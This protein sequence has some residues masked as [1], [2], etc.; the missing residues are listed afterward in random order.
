MSGPPIVD[1]PSVRTTAGF[2]GYMSETG[3]A[4]SAN[5]PVKV[6]VTWL[7]IISCFSAHHVPLKFVSVFCSGRFWSRYW[8]QVS[9]LL[10]PD[11]HT[12]RFLSQYVT[13]TSWHGR[14]RVL[15]ALGH[16]VLL[17]GQSCCTLTMIFQGY[18][19]FLKGYSLRYCFMNV[20]TRHWFWK[21]CVWS[22]YV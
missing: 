8:L 20:L 17:S 16:S 3:S 10:S 9:L 4:I 1:Q 12:S 22:V 21:L 15:W 7:K 19:N 5:C 6:R 2:G 11:A 13:C 14:G 18:V